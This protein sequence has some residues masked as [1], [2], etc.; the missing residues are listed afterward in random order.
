[1]RGQPR[2]RANHLLAHWLPIREYEI[3][4]WVRT[5]LLGLLGHLAQ[6]D[7]FVCR[8]VNLLS[9]SPMKN[10]PAIRGSHL[11]FAPPITGA[12]TPNDTTQPLSQDHFL[13]IANN[14]RL[15]ERL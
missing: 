7:W 6:L 5:A 11:T 3:V 2:I 12:S 9:H 15:T 10:L 14:P 13:R 8:H 4:R 1:M